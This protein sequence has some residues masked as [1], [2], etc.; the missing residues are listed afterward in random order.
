M[1]ITELIRQFQ[2]RSDC[3]VLPPQGPPIISESH[4][5]PEDLHKFYELCGGLELYQQSAFPLSV[6]PPERV[7]LA[8]PVIILGVTE[9]QLMESIDD[10]SWSWYIIAE[11]HSGQYITIDFSPERLGRCYNSFWELHPGNSVMVAYSFTDFLTRL[12]QADGEE[13]YWDHPDF[14]PLG[15]E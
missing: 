4:V 5:I 10:I 1:S 12:A 3:I 11:G 2:A 13:W 6:V 15:S 8:N 9:E 7:M 14:V